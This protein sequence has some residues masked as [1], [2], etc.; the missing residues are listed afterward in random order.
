VA[1]AKDDKRFRWAVFDADTGKV[2][3]RGAQRF[4][5]QAFGR[6]HEVIVLSQD[7]GRVVFKDSKTASVFAV[8]DG[9]ET[10]LPRTTAAAGSNYRWGDARLEFTRDSRRVMGINS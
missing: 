2:V 5:R 6:N 4:S 10:V 1:A 7:G 9:A 3:G 8:N